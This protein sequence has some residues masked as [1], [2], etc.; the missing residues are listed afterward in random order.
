MDI[1][2]QNIFIR[3]KVWKKVEFGESGVNSVISKERVMGFE[4]IEVDRGQIV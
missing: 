3:G 1:W 4:F 2:G